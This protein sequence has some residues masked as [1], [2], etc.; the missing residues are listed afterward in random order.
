MTGTVLARRTTDRQEI[1]RWVESN[2][3]V[4]ARARGSAV[5]GGCA[6]RID[7][8]GVA[9]EEQPEHVDWSTWF[10]AFDAAGLELVYRPGADG[11]DGRGTYFRLVPR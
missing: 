8:P 2:G 6:L 11:E 4:P 7:F 10:T 3:G 9:A 1:R 5:A